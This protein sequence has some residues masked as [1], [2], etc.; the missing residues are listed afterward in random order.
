MQNKNKNIKSNNSMYYLLTWFSPSF[1]IG[2]YAYSH[3]LEYAIESKTINNISDLENWLS[4]F[5]NYGTCYNDGIL[6]SSA[7]DLSLIHI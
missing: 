4:D 6:I 3:G 2:A 5:L 1:P 7:Y